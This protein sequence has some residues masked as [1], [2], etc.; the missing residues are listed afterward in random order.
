MYMYAINDWGSEG[1]VKGPRNE[2]AMVWEWG[3]NGLGMRQQWSG[4]EASLSWF[5]A[6][7]FKL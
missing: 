7:L 5:S 4:N 1:G 3:S 6:A 2:A